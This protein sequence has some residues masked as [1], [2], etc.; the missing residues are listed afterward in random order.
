MAILSNSEQP[1][2]EE[3]SNGHSSWYTTGLG[4][5]TCGRIVQ[6]ASYIIVWFVIV[7]KWLALVK[8]FDLSSM[9]TCIILG[10]LAVGMHH[11]AMKCVRRGRKLRA[12]SAEE[13]MRKGREMLASRKR[14]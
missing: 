5:V 2:S 4:W 6:V 9:V 3:D 12:P 14:S 7:P 1:L 8:H 13:I 10:F 11:A